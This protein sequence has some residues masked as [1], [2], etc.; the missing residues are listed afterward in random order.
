MRS[1]RCGELT[2]RD[3]GRPVRLAGW[4]HRLRD[5]GGITFVDLRDA[6]GI[7]QIIYRDLDQ[8][9]RLSRED[10]IQVE[11]TVARR[12]APNPDLASGEVEVEATALRV[13]AQ[14]APLPFAVDD[15][16][17]GAGEETRLKYRFIDLR[18]PRMQRNLALRHR[19]CMAIRAFLDAEEFVEVETPVLT[20]STPEGARDFLVP[21]RL[22]PGSFYA[23]P[24]SPQLFK[25]ILIASGVER[26]F[27]IVRCFRDEDL[28]ADRQPE[29]TQLDVEMGFLDTPEPLFELLEGLMAYVFG[30]ASGVELATPFPRLTYA[31][32]MADYGSDKPDL[33]FGMKLVEVSDLFADAGFRVFARAVA[34]GG[35]V[36]AL[37]VP[38]GAELSRGELD[39]VEEQAVAL[40]APGLSWLKRAE[41]L[42]SPLAKFVNQGVL[43]GVADK[44]GAEEGDVVLISAG[45]P[46]TLNPALGELR[47]RLAHARGLVPDDVWAPAWIT[48]FPLF[49]RGEGGRLDSEH[50]PF[51]APRDEDLALLDEDALSA[52][53]KCYDL[54]L[55]G[56]ELASG[57]IR[58]HRRDVQ[59]RILA[60]LGIG[61]EEAER[62]FG[63]FLRAL[64][65]GAPPHGGIA[66]G[67]DRWVMMLAGERTLREVIAFPKTAGGSCPLTGAPAPVDQAQ[68]KEL[69]LAVEG[70][71]EDETRSSSS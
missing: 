12:E 52:R 27:Q 54:V 8:A 71:T 13:L 46:S 62:R 47:R 43:Q 25:Q 50:H 14:A 53:A 42:S 18:R 9:R 58:I 44:A 66:F 4:V 17:S 32:A 23:L 57:S 63:F 67:L 3:V 19:V 64:E 24:Q 21:C 69:G 15:D 59:Q 48:D 31:R 16:V 38:G 61:Q 65:Y 33:R 70:W 30:E 2:A 51:T 26:Y 22:V 34:D 5:L 37:R 29:F 28:R 45:V 7:V 10:V 36:R 49:K 1:D 56:V 20:R 55:N 68:L 40:G 41:E 11:G 60:L 39:K 35:Q 6:S